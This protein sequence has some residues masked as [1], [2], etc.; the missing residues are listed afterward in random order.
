MSGNAFHSISA[1]ERAALQMLCYICLSLAT[2]VG[3]KAADLTQTVATI[4]PSVVAI[5]T[6]Q[7]TRSPPIAFFGTGFSVADGLTVLTNA[8]VVVPQADAEKSGVLGV[9]VSNGATT[10]FPPRR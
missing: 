9:L 2:Q 3:A 7:K 4:K 5:A 10:E 8:H 6:M 1:V